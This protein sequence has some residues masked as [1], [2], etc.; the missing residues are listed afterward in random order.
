MKGGTPWVFLNSKP[1]G[2]K[3]KV[4][5]QQSTY[6]VFKLC[7]GGELSQVASGVCCVNTVVTSRASSRGH[8]GSSALESGT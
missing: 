8:G 5:V 2:H 6:L 7:T 3:N 1:T 4:A